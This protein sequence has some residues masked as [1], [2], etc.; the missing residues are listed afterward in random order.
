M[1]VQML[2]HNSGR[3]LKSYSLLLINFSPSRNKMAFWRK[4]CCFWVQE[5]SRTH[6]FQ[7]T[8]YNFCQESSFLTPLIVEKGQVL[9]FIFEKGQGEILTP[10]KG[11]GAILTFWKKLGTF[12]TFFYK[13]IR[14]RQGAAPSENRKTWT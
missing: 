5:F 9:F 8:F 12:L 10:K 6:T 1:N 2:K 4:I 3:D 11:Q 7:V 13:R 14:T